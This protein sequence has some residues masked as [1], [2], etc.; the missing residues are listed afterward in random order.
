M[1]IFLA[2][3]KIDIQVLFPMLKMKTSAI[4][5]WGFWDF[6]WILDFI[7]LGTVVDYCEQ[8]MHGLEN[9]CRMKGLDNCRA[10]V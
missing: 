9:L 3:L 8:K 4:P 10:M 2:I 1:K 5:C 7:G 6:A